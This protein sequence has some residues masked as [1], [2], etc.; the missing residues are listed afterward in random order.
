MFGR[1][2][3]SK[4]LSTPLCIVT[5]VLDVASQNVVLSQM[6]LSQ[7]VSLFLLPVCG[8]RKGVTISGTVGDRG[9]AERI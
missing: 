4:V 5:T 8:T 2:S 1:W 9:N 6:H 3:P 7:I